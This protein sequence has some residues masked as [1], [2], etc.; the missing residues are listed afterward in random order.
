MKKKT[1]P[2]ALAEARE[3]LGGDSSGGPG[4]NASAAAGDKAGEEARRS[5]T[6]DEPQRDAIRDAMALEDKDQ[7]EQHTNA[8]WIAAGDRMGF[9]HTTARE[10]IDFAES[11]VFSAIPLEPVDEA[12]AADL[13]V[14]HET[15]LERMEAAA[16]AVMLEAGRLVDG[17]QLAILE[18]I[19]LRPRPW[20]E[21]SEDEQR[22][23]IAACL[24]AAKELVRKTVETVVETVAGNGTGAVR[25]LLTK[26]N[27]G[28]D[29]VISGKVK[30]ADPTN[31]DAAVTMLH[32][33]RGKHVLVMPASADDFHAG[34]EVRAEADEPPLNFEADDED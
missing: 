26:I 5:Y 30:V 33:A 12:P 31:E 24:H 10:S 2:A 16:S 23:V 9:D 7:R 21:T 28:D 13:H 8:F 14:Q 18:Q 17:L 32:H 3:H 34:T 15:A 22:D 19:K 6:L 1:G 27:I 4:D 20:K 29:I 11:G 25:V